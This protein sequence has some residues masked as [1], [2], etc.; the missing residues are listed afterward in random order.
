MLIAEQIIQALEAAGFRAAFLP[1]SAMEQVREHYDTLLARGPDTDWLKSAVK[2]F[3]E[4]QPPKLDF[5]PKSILVTG[6]GNAGGKLVLHRKGEAVELPVP[7]NCVAV[8]PPEQYIEN[9]LPGI[10]EGW[11]MGPVRGVSTK[12][13]AALSGLGRYGRNNIIYVGD[14]GSYVGLYDCYTDIPYDGPVQ[15]NLRM[16]ACESC[17]LCRRACPTGAI[18][19]TQVIDASH[20]LSHANNGK[21]GPMP[22]WVPK[23][24]HHCLVE[25]LRC[26]E[27]CPQNPPIDFSHTLELDEDETRRLLSR[28]KRMPKDLA[29]RLGDFGMRGWN[30]D[31]LKRN[32]RLFVE[33]KL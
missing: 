13:L 1:I 12:L 27:C 26:Q 25:C 32:A 22:R 19:D 6:R 33:A 17:E 9:V 30:M 5:E 21:K 23:G 3:Q 11:Q 10:M 8:T 4:N 7:P 16:A 31:G 29:K 24:A 14:W 18:G 2:R 20:C 15:E 28:R